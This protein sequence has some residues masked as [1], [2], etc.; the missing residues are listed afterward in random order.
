MFLSGIPLLKRDISVSILHLKSFMCRWMLPFMRRN[1][2]SL[3]L[4]FRGNCKEDKLE[5]LG[6]SCLES[7]TLNFSSIKSNEFG[8]SG[9]DS[10]TLDLSHSSHDSN[11]LNLFGLESNPPN[12]SS[13]KS[14]R[15]NISGLELNTLVS[16]PS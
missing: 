10:N 9:H 11:T 12:S 4:I 3:N 16:D 14:N 15:P 5:S 1:R 13:F 2:T 7:T 6:L 8:H